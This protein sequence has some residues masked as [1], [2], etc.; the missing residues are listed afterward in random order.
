M[1]Q[2]IGEH[3]FDNAYR[4]VAPQP[5]SP[6]YVVRGNQ[7]ALTQARE[8]ADWPRLRFAFTL[9]GVAH[10]IAP[11]DVALNP[12]GLD[13][14]LVNFMRAEGPA[15][16]VLASAVAV[17]L[18]RWYE[19]NRHCS[20]CGAALK[21]APASR[22]L[23]CEDCGRIV[24]PTLTPGIIAG[25]IDREANK[26]LLTTYANRVNAR[27]ALVAGFAEVGES[28]EGCL[29]REV[30]EETGLEVSNIQYVASQPWPYSDSLL[31]GF[32]CEV[33]GSRDITLEEAELG[34]AEWVAPCDMPSREGDTVSLTGHMM[35]LFAANGAAVLD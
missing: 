22:E 6:V 30:R 34:R 35:R 7:V 13:F 24:Y 20:W 4:E 12:A 21:H 28:L 27:P 26:I 29:R 16:A 5:E 2:E 32:F 8:L 3:V 15:E 9:D 11:F 33:E 1:I 14:K 18:A 23:V 19:A 25:V 10:F 31:V 17:Q